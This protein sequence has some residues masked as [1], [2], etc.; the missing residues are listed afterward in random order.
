MPVGGVAMKKTDWLVLSC[1]RKNA[2]M[3][4]TRMSRETKIPVSTIFDK[5]KEF[6]HKVIKRH[7]VL[8]DFR[9]LGFDVRLSLLLKIGQDVRDE[10]LSFL[11]AS[12]HVNNLWKVSSGFDVLVECVFRDLPEMSGFLDRLDAFPILDRRE[13]LVMEDMRREAFLADTDLVRLSKAKI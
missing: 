2:R 4:L 7:T 12:E 1:L 5:L 3:P 10:A 8:M 13:F 6:E 11:M 9:S